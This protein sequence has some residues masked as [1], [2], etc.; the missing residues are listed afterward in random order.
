MIGN[1]H[2][3]VHIAELLISDLCKLCTD[4]TQHE[5]IEMLVELAHACYAVLIVYNAILSPDST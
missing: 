1:L 4:M 2:L 3:F 5:I